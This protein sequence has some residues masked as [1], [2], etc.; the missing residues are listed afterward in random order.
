MENRTHQQAGAHQRKIARSRN[1]RLQL[2]L[3]ETLQ[4]TGLQ[5]ELSDR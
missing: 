5:D 4:A 1:W 2:E 3:R